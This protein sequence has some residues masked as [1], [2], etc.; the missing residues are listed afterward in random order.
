MA[1]IETLCLMCN[2]PWERHCGQCNSAR[3]CSVNCQK[4]DWPAHKLLCA[5]FADFAPTSRPSEDDYRAIL[6]SVNKGPQFIWLK[7][8]L[9]AELHCWVPDRK[10]EAKLLGPPKCLTDYSIIQYN[11]TLDRWLP[12]TLFISYRDDYMIDGSKVNKSICEATEDRTIHTYKGPVLVYGSIGLNNSPAA[13][14]DLTLI[15]YAHVIDYFKT[16]NR[17]TGSP[18]PKSLYQKLVAEKV[19]VQKAG[20]HKVKAAI[21]LCDGDLKASK[22]GLRFQMT[23]I[24]LNHPIFQEHDM[25]KTAKLLELPLLT[26]KN[27]LDTRFTPVL[28]ASVVGE[29]L[30]SNINADVLHFDCDLKN[31][32]PAMPVSQPYPAATLRGPGSILVVRQ[33]KK[34]LLPMHV[35]AMCEYIRQEINSNVPRTYTRDAEAEKRRNEQILAAMSPDKFQAFWNQWLPHQRYPVPIP[36]PIDR[37]RCWVMELGRAVGYVHC[38]A[39]G[40]VLDFGYGKEYWISKPGFFVY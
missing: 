16:V 5:S 11:Q 9:I 14:K 10:S 25:P 27:S 30:I 18:A 38:L 22:K 36:S 8:N 33:D 29:R 21:I 2:S 1:D 24:V 34:P 31:Y 7:H 13:S 39:T 28:N 17:F 40:C 4:A 3:Y 37:K 32:R 35:S 6:F 23:D 15:D 12:D 19:M 26:R 20:E